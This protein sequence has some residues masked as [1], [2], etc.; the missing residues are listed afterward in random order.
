MI[1]N[2][3]GCFYWVFTNMAKGTGGIYLGIM[4]SQ[5]LLLRWLAMLRSTLTDLIQAAKTRGERA[6]T[7]SPS[8]ILRTI[9]L[10]HHLSHLRSPHNQL[11]QLLQEGQTNSLW[12]LIQIRARKQLGFIVHRRMVIGLCSYRRVQVPSG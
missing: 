1:T 2:G 10:P 9:A 3:A 8:P 4:Y 7:T 11:Q 5:G 12:Q 6:Y